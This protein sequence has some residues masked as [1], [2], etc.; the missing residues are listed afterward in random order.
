MAF[1]LALAKIDETH[2][3]E[4]AKAMGG[5]S[6]TSVITLLIRAAV[7]DN[8]AIREGIVD[9]FRERLAESAKVPA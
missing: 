6:K 2:L 8:P 7:A 9:Q 3:A 4:L 5:V 1:T